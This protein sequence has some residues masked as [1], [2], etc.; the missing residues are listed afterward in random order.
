MWKF[1]GNAQFRQSFGRI[2]RHSTE[3][4]RFHKWNYG[5]LCILYWNLLKIPVLLKAIGLQ[6]YMKN[7]IEQMSL[8]DLA[9]FSEKLVLKFPWAKA[10]ETLA[11]LTGKQSTICRHEALLLEYF[12]VWNSWSLNRCWLLNR[13]TWKQGES[14]NTIPWEKIHIKNLEIITFI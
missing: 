10:S 5:T 1:C 14:G 6:F 13:F 8:W 2:T 4:V 3:T 12:L 11:F 9:V 7:A